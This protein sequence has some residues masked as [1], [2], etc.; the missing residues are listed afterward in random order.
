MHR[1][2]TRRLPGLW[3]ARL[4]RLVLVPVLLGLVGGLAGIQL[5]AHISRDIGPVSATMSLQ[6]SAPVPGGGTEVDIPPLGSLRFS[7]HRG[8][9][10]LVVGVLRLNEADVRQILNRQLGSVSSDR[11]ATD[12][13]R[14]I[15]ALVVRCLIASSVGGLLLGLV[16]YR[17]L[18][19]TLLTGGISVAFL[20]VALGV[21]GLTWNPRR[22]CSLGT[23]ACSTAHPR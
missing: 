13:R 1:T 20:A 3:T 18:R 9:L 11:I 14:G 6:P 5:G 21:A 7:T 8:P 12:V 23:R 19:P 22:S 10:R 4:V 17:R 15:V 16:A 2:T